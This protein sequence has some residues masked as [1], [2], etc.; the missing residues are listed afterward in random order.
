MGKKFSAFV[1]TIAIS[2]LCSS[3]LYYLVI[4]ITEFFLNSSFTRIS[5][6]VAA[7]ILILNF[8]ILWPLWQ[9]KLFIYFSRKYNLGLWPTPIFYFISTFGFEISIFFGLYIAGN[10]VGVPKLTYF[11]KTANEIYFNSLE[12]IVV[13]FFVVFTLYTP[14]LYFAVNRSFKKWSS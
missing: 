4:K 14:L 8:L 12:D 1:I 3:L 5:T 6:T 2:Y 9:L 10:L 7:V 13:F 11:G